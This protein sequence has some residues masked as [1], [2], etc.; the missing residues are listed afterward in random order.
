MAESMAGRRG[1]PPASPAGEADGGQTRRSGETE[2]GD[3]R[4]E[5]RR[6]QVDDCGFLIS[7]FEILTPCSMPHALCF[8][9]H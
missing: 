5:D 7:N 8:I 1:D 9:S 2:I 3:Q 4:P 6:Q